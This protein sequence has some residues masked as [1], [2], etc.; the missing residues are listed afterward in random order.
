MSSCWQLATS[1]T[2]KGFG[3]SPCV[4]LLSHNQ[5]SPEGLC[6]LPSPLTHLLLFFLRLN[7]YSGNAELNETQPCLAELTAGTQDGGK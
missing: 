6:L 5:I 2:Y 7:I 4:A 1:A 3:I